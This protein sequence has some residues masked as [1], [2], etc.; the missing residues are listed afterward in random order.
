MSLSSLIVQREIATI[1]QVEE[2][3]ARQVLYGGD[4]VTN[5]L[6]V[7]TV[8][9]AKLNDAA[10]EA[11]GILP[12]PSGVL[13]DPDPRARAL[14]PGDLA[15]RRA[16]YPLRMNA[17]A[18]QL[19][20]AVAEPLNAREEEEL[21]FALGVPL[22]QRLA[23][24]VRVRQALARVYG[25]PLERRYERLTQRL[26]GESVGVSESR[27]PLMAEPPAPHMPPRPESVAPGRFTGARIPSQRPTNLG[28][29]AVDAKPMSPA[30]PLALEGI[31]NP[32]AP[33]EP[34]PTDPM[35]LPPVVVRDERRETLLR[36]L[37]APPR[38]ARRRRGPMTL[39]KAR[40]ELDAVETRDG[41][42]DLFFD[43]ARQ[44]FEYAAIFVVHGDVAEGRDAYGPGADRDKVTGIGV[45][46]DLPGLF[47]GARATSGPILRAP[48][49]DGL[50]AVLLTDL[51][52][53]VQSAVVALPLIVRGR[54]VAI[55]YGDAADAG[56]DTELVGDVVAFAALVGQAFEKIILRKKLGGYS[57]G[58]P[59]SNA[60]RADV[61]DLIT[62]K[63]AAA[64]PKKIPS[65]P[66]DTTRA[67]E[68]LGRAIL[69]PQETSVV[70]PPFAIPKRRAGAAEP[71]PPA[72]S[73]I[74][75]RP[76][77]PPIPRE[78]PG[79]APVRADERLP[80]TAHVA[81]GS[82]P[83]PP[84][85]LIPLSPPP[86]EVT[87]QDLD[88]EAARSLLTEIE[89]AQQESDG[90]PP[91]QSSIAVPPRRPP[92]S[93]TPGESL[94]SVIVDV[95]RELEV[96]VER[97]IQNVDD[98]QAEAELLRQGQHAMGA[99]IARFPGPIVKEPRLEEEDGPPVSACGPLLRLLTMQRRIAVP[100]ILPFLD[101]NDEE[102]RFWATFAVTELAYP[103]IVPVLMPRFSDPS[104]RVR[105]AA[106]LAAAAIARV[107]GDE[108]AREIGRVVRDTAMDRG[109][110]LEMLGVL[111]DIRC[112]FAVPT[113]IAVLADADEEVALA[114]R[115]ALTVVTRQDFARDAKRWT[116]WWNQNSS[117]HRVE[118]LID[119]LVHESQGVRRASGEELK[120]ITKEYFGYYD[121]LPKRERDRA[122]A[123]YR[124][125]WR[126]EGHLRFVR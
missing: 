80:P 71:P 117:R 90:P 9:E 44:Y 10:A 50:D 91:S 89:A 23:S 73:V 42:L 84:V 22:E 54:A 45:P 20:V 93:R 86:P 14:I 98:E 29:P 107:H 120:A 82:T 18:E 46:L 24:V 41:L 3:L 123:R 30:P 26:R 33:V 110:R 96:L 81:P 28:F 13:P 124:E 76:S 85:A 113:F 64:Q 116:T 61:S 4:L 95:S 48:E 21:M 118:W 97:F 103:E 38:R 67:A 68:A 5:L 100:S 53:K 34:T 11:A 16:L 104:E 70:E 106:R 108:V 112:A 121:D 74:V 99:I 2:A 6:E 60:G 63:L 27:P 58:T 31:Q 17:D 15:N 75:R 87:S 105:R 8:D 55:L 51:E 109:K 25:A 77:G 114:A 35:S 12:A 39:D 66:V 122:Q 111:E 7:A 62:Q 43:F 79:V 101:G 1:R 57:A 52:R 72:A 78:D 115:R 19:L 119:A 49:P 59:G 88:D 83:P 47:A 56:V 102:R 65:A 92:S 94:P 32:E 37:S 69:T 36:E 126:T 40:T 125:W